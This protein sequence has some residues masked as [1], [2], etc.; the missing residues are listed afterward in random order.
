MKHPDLL[1]ESGQR[2]WLDM[3]RIS[4]DL[5]L[6]YGLRLFFRRA[7]KHVVYLMQKDIN[8]YG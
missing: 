8:A 7:F 1:K 6:V 3:L 2:K 4:D 5:R